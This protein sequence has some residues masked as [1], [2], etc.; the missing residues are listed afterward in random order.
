MSQLFDRAIESVR[1][2]SPEAQDEIARLLLQL[3]TEAD[4]PPIPMTDKEE[5]S[6]DVSFRQAE[7]GE[8]ASDEAVWAKRGL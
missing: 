4:A 7:R 6:F 8:F 5:A 3:T 2:L 1:N